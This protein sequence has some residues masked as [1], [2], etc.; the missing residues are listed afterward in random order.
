M[1]H[2]T[3]DPKSRRR[4][5]RVSLSLALG[6]IAAL[7]ILSFAG[8]A[9]HA[10]R[11]A[12]ADSRPRR[13][14]VSQPQT[15]QQPRPTPAATT[16]APQ[17]QT[18]PQPR[19]TPAPGASPS[20]SPAEGQDPGQEVDPDEIVKVDTS[21]VNLNVRV[22]DRANRPVNDVRQE[23]FKI[24]EDGVPQQIFSFTRAEVPISYGLVVDNSG[25]MKTQLEKVID[26]TRTIIEQNKPGDETF[27]QRFVSSDEIS[28]L[29]DFTANKDDLIDAMDK[30]H[31]EGGQTAVLDAVYLAAEHVGKHKK[32]DPLNDKRRRALILVTDGEDRSSYYK[33]AELFEFLRENDVQIYVIG[34]VNELETDSGF[35]RKST[36]DKSVN[37]LNKI[38][39]ET[40]GRA[41]Y[42]MSLA[43]LPGIADEITRDLRTQYVVSY[44]PTNKR[45]DGTFR[46]VNV[47]I[48]DTAKRDK[49]IAI[50]RPG[51]T[52][53]R[54]GGGG[55]APAPARATS[56][57]NKQP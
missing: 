8:S 31:T 29:Q 30:M 10:Q 17:L 44:S 22:I 20:A 28:I 3:V 51:Y 11:T 19:L 7:A 32:G 35:I 55:S 18:P 42:P 15:P 2:R 12:A 53:P 23:E 36:K 56:T 50:T 24:F 46:K 49:R 38:A 1:T 26:A 34:F 43:E 14:N 9:T 16:P 37:L 5:S 40:G 6:L 48:E 25:S 27:L 33:Q 47:R 41:F 21:L 57:S 45:R 4:N 39:T 54:G 13:V 52:A